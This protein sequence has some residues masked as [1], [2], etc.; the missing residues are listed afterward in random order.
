MNSRSGK[1]IFYASILFLVMVSSIA[2]TAFVPVT[3]AIRSALP[4]LPPIDSTSPGEA[5]PAAALPDF[6]AAG[7]L[8][9]VPDNP[10]TQSTNAGLPG[11]TIKFNVLK[12]VN[13]QWGAP[14]DEK[15]T[16]GVYLDQGKKFG[17]YWD[18]PDP[19]L[20]PD[21]T[22]LLPIYPS[23]RIGGNHREQSSLANFPIKM[24]DLRS[25][26][27]LV[28]YNYPQQ[29][30]GTYNFSYDMFLLDRDKSSSEAIRKA[31]IMIWLQ[32]TFGQPPQYYKG[33]VSDGYHNYALYSY[34]MPDGRLYRAFIMKDDSRLQSQHYVDVK[35]LLDQLNLDPDWCLPGVELG[36]EIVNGSGKIE[37][38]RFSVNLN[39]SVI[40]P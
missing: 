14:P 8:S 9:Q 26:S 12:L 37:I 21:G 3:A 10:V 24:R 28:D 29:P 23:I 17:W 20:K 36:N 16:S 40:E 13:N 18:R 11:E 19:R 1:L 25:L 4:A 27:F 35:K 39:G 32:H 15:L 5:L 31:E 2:S 30:T 6:A 33:D 38:D 7:K 22:I 34:T